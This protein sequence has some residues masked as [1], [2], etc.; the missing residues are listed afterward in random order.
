MTYTDE[1]L[2]ALFARLESGLNEKDGDRMAAC[3]ADNAIW[4]NPAAML[5][6]GR[7]GIGEK[8]RT[9]LA[10]Y[11]KDFYA[12]YDLLSAVEIGDEVAVVHIRQ[13]PITRDGGD[14]GGRPGSIAS[15]VCRRQPGGWRIVSAQ[16]TVEDREWIDQQH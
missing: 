13:T 15:Y 7:D 2:A 5:T 14:F 16:N 9:S 12:R 1:G 6:R 4:V 8:F 11:L 10:T 3:L